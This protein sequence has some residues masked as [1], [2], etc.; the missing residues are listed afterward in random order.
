MM[1]GFAHETKRQWLGQAYA[2]EGCAAN[3]IART[4]VPDIRIAYRY[5]TLLEEL[6]RLSHAIVHSN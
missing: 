2:K 3:E 6:H 4:N 1:S 5:E